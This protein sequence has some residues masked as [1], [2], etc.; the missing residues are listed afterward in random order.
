[1]VA[2]LNDV[3]KC[4]INTDSWLVNNSNYKTATSV[5]KNKVNYHELF[6]I[7]TASII[8]GF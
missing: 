6:I 7:G 8:C 4:V 1:M 5:Q 3:T 2:K